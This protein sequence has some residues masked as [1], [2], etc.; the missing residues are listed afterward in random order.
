MSVVWYQVE[1][2]SVVSVVWCKVE[3]LS[4]VSVV[5]CQVEVL[6]VVSVVWCQ[7]SLQRAD[8]S[9]RGILP[10]VMRRCV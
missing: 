8:H 3:V 6:S 2:L 7:R 5:W 4:V 1:V 9:F 10:T